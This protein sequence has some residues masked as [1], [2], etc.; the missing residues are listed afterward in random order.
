MTNQ[1]LKG[2][3]VAGTLAAGFFAQAGP[4]SATSIVYDFARL[5]LAAYPSRDSG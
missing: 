2:A 3:L 4:A 5:P 1:I